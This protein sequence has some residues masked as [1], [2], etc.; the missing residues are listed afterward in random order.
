MKLLG[1]FSGFYEQLMVVDSAGNGWRIREV[2]SSYKKSWWLT[3]LVHTVFNPSVDVQ[4]IWEEPRSISLEDVKSHYL[5]AVEADDDI[6]TQ[7]VEP[8][9]LKQKI[10]EAKSLAAL[11]DVCRWA[12]RD[13]K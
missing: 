3:I 5:K 13:F 12:Q 4:F 8:E 10:I 2:R 1:V 9:V 11:G 7:F 6:L